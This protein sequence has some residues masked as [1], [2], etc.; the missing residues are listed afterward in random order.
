[1]EKLLF[2]LSEDLVTY[3]IFSHNSGSKDYVGKSYDLKND[4]VVRVHS[5]KS[6]NAVSHSILNDFDRMVYFAILVISKELN[7]WNITTCYE[8]ILDLIDKKNTANQRRRVKDSIARLL[9]T[10]VEIIKIDQKT[11]EPEKKYKVIQTIQFLDTKSE[12]SSPNHTFSNKIT[13]PGKFTKGFNTIQPEQFLK[14]GIHKF[15]KRVITFDLNDILALQDRLFQRLF[16]FLYSRKCYSNQ[17][18]LNI[19]LKLFANTLP[20]ASSSQS[21]THSNKK[22]QKGLELMKKIGLV[23]DYIF[24][25]AQSLTISRYVITLN[26]QFLP[27]LNRI[28]EAMKCK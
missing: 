23:Q 22:I 27:D 1:M 15:E 9:A 7:S 25:P 3:P 6:A 14:I 13:Y 18:F 24:I 2:N 4:I 26:R 19:N 8:E 17:N 10:K 5:P 16:M 20:L 12:H 28:K 11:K 21:I